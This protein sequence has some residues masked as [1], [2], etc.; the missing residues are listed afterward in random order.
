MS[1]EEWLESQGITDPESLTAEALDALM[2][3]YEAETAEGDP[4]ETEEEETEEEEVSEPVAASGAG[5]SSEIADA[6]VEKYK[7]QLQAKNKKIKKL[8]A[9]H[10]REDFADKAISNNWS[11][12]ETLSELLKATRDSRSG[13][14]PPKR[15]GAK[16]MDLN[17]VLEASLLKSAG[18]SP[19][20]SGY[21]EAVLKAA[22][23]AE[24]ADVGLHGLL[25]H[26]S[27]EAGS[28]ISAM[29][30][31]PQKLK[32]A[33][34]GIRMNASSGPSTL[35]VS[36]ILS[37]LANKFL[38]AGYESNPSVVERLCSRQSSRDFKQTSSYRLVDNGSL[39][40]VPPGGEIKHGKLTDQTFN[41]KVN[42]Y[43]KMISIDRQQLLNDDLGAFSN[44]TRLLG[45]SAF[46]SREKVVFDAIVDANG[47]TFYTDANKNLINT[48]ATAPY[49][50]PNPLDFNG[51]ALAEQRLM[52]QTDGSEESNP[53]A[54]MGAFVVCSPVN[55]AMAWR[56]YN[57]Q[58]LNETTAAAEPAGSTN[59]FQNKYEPLVSPFLTGPDWYLASSPNNVSSFEIVY[60]N[61][62]STPIVESSDM[63]FNQLGIQTRVIFDFGFALQD[64]RG[65][66]LSVGA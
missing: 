1:F 8:C 4:E 10:G 21:S 30:M 13:Y 14:V 46:N 6:A 26:A 43:G 47:G 2:K 31:S 58:L 25:Y 48:G 34:D 37:N 52:E 32:A 45:Q 59:I 22:G 56:L 49:G 35:S 63:D 65:S 24:Y 17:Q 23:T 42:T 3:Q 5:E 40:V 64:P 7:K 61:G 36:G 51:L 18:Y 20:D 9:S 55:S 27:K 50:Q 53:I 62:R 16:P 15:T 38:L 12:T 54:I 29:G 28:P 39:Q 66:V 57:S 33:F 41:N 44:M 19:E 60:L 11:E